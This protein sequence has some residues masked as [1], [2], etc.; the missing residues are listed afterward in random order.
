[1]DVSRVVIHIESLSLRGVEYQDRLRVAAG[2]RDELARGLSSPAAALAWAT[3]VNTRA[4]RPLQVRVAHDSRPEQTGGAVGRA[5][6][7]PAIA[8]VT[9]AVRR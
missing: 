8:T 5:L 4:P 3:A 2:I 9:R 6:V 7:G 1:M